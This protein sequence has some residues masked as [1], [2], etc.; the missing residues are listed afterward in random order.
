MQ[1]VLLSGV[2]GFIGSQITLQLLNKGY[3]VTG[4][5]RSQKKAE[6]LKNSLTPHTKHLENLAFV[7]ADLNDDTVWQNLCQGMDFVQHIASPFPLEIPKDENELIAPA[8]N[9]TESVLKAAASHGI[10]RVVLTS[11]MASVVYGKN[12]SERSG[13][14]NETHWSSLEH[15]EDLTPYYKSKTV[16]EKAAWEF[17]E[18]NNSDLELATVCPSLVL[19]PFHALSV[20]TSVDLIKQLFDGSIPA[21]PRIGFEV[22][23][24][25]SVADLHIRAMENPKAK[26][27]RFLAAAGYISMKELVELLHQHYPKHK[28]PKLSLPDVVVRLIAKFDKTLEATLV[29]LGAKRTIDHSKAKSLLG[30]NPISPQ[31]AILASAECL[32]SEGLIPE[33]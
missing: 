33:K 27:E 22:V 12:R 20:G 8:R 4:T 30:W 6:A 17:I 16:A 25:R 18:N 13:H 23:D 28:L 1:K 9:G 29:E 10:K 7:E 3:H 19:G 21:I 2:T 32:F 15:P 24:V 31:D 26:N 11:S 5:L 14:F